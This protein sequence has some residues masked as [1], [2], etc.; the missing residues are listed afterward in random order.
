MSQDS[1]LQG[2]GRPLSCNKT[3]S[4]LIFSDS[5]SHIIQIKQNVKLNPHHHLESGINHARLLQLNSLCGTL[6]R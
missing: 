3:Q 6:I 5:F 2:T 4:V 1:S